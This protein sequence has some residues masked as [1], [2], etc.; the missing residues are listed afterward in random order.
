MISLPD[1]HLFERV[2]AVMARHH[3]DRN[4]D[5]RFEEIC[6]AARLN[7]ENYERMNENVSTYRM[8][9]YFLPQISARLIV[10]VGCA[11]ERAHR[12]L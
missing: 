3:V 2:W 12:R 4:M 11:H 9:L 7:I 1:E 5:D 10:H 8:P 6:R